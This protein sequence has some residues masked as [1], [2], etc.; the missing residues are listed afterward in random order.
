MQNNDMI[1]KINILLQS[2]IQTNQIANDTGISKV[3]ISNLR[4]K[5]ADIS[6]ATFE[7]VNKLYNYYLDR[8]DY[9]ELAKT[10]EKDILNVKLPKDVQIF[11]TKLKEAVDN[12]N[13]ITKSLHISEITLEKSFTMSKDKKSTKLISKIK[14]DELIPIQIKRN[15]FAYSLKISSDFVEDK[16]PLDNITDFQ[17]DFSYNDL[18]IDLKRHIHLGN[19]VV[20]ITSNLNELGES[21]TGIYVNGNNGGYNYELNFISISI[22]S[23][24]RK[25]DKYE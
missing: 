8:K 2:D 19:R 10:I 18:E 22:F 5:T 4:R 3:T 17:I 15:T 6:K 23:N 14:L 1:S 20:L 12:I 11:I 16:T 7:T 25:G 9:L 13:D 21:Q 24:D